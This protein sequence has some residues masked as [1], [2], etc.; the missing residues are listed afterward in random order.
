MQRKGVAAQGQRSGRWGRRADAAVPV[1]GTPT[2]V[3]QDQHGKR[4]QPNGKDRNKDRAARTDRETLP[5]LAGQHA[6]DDLVDRPV[7]AHHRET[8]MAVKGP[9]VPNRSQHWIPNINQHPIS[10]G[11]ERIIA[12]GACGVG[13]S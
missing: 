8:V 1:A 10:V 7:A 13:W 9:E 11:T 4:R 5:V 3:Q 6:V 12:H 2:W